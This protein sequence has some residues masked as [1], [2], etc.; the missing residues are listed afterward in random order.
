MFCLWH[1]IQRHSGSPQSGEA[2]ARHD[3]PEWLA[4]LLEHETTLRRLHNDPPYLIALL[5]VCSERPYC[6]RAA[7]Q[8]REVASFQPIKPHAVPPP[9]S[10]GSQD[11]G[12][13]EVS[14]RVS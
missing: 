4:L 10:E 1:L 9:T 13:A 7:D 3:A 12:F 6:C 11:T 8:G 5:R 14:H 2:S